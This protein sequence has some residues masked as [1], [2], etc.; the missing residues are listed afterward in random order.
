MGGEYQKMLGGVNMRE[1]KIY[2]K[3]HQTRLKYRNNWGRGEFR[4]PT[5]VSLV[6]PP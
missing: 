1:M 2:I 4:L 6:P 3:K 5:G